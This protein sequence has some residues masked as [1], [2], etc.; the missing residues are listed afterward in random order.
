VPTAFISRV[1]EQVSRFVEHFSPNCRHC[2]DF[3]PT[4]THLTEDTK[5]THDPGIQLA[6][7]NCLAYG[8]FCEQNGVKYYPQLNLYRNG[9][10]VETFDG[11][12]EYDALLEYMNKH[13]EPTSTPQVTAPTAVK[14]PSATKPTK[15]LHIQTPQADINPAGLVLELGS[16]NFQHLIDQGPVF[17]KFFAPWYAPGDLCISKIYFDF[18]IGVATARSLHQSGHY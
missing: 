12:R 16:H 18:S 1:I 17:I 13:A 3:A 8:D 2:K 9:Q 14:V 15:I 6:Q 4:W 5:N 10:F 7:I 11:A